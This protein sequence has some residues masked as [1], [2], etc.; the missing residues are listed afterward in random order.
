MRSVFMV[1]VEYLI[2]IVN[3]T[4]MTEQERNRIKKRIARQ[5]AKQNELAGNYKCGQKSSTT[6]RSHSKGNLWNHH[7]EK[8]TK[9]T[10][11]EY[12]IKTRYHA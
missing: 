7:N 4:N 9:D 3:R 10:V 6:R 8:I 5:Q 1:N 11:V 2:K 12:T